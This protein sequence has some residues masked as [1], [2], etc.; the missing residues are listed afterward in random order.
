MKM[1]DMAALAVL[2][3]SCDVV[4]DLGLTESHFQ[5]LI[6]KTRFKTFSVY[7]AQWELLI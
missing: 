2:G 7:S 1:P 4:Q 3:F 5:Q 6:I